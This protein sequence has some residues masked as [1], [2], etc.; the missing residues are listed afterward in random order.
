M[1][2]RRPVEDG[3]E[4]TAVLRKAP[5]VIAAMSVWDIVED[6]Q[7]ERGGKTIQPAPAKSIDY[8]L[9]LPLSHPALSNFCPFLLTM[10]WMYAHRAP[11]L[12]PVWLK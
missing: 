12:Q 11:A 4:D 6:G 3:L 5:G 9:S 2:G 10:T 1:E 8:L 7:D